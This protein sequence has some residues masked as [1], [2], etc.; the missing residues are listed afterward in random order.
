MQSAMRPCAYSTILPEMCGEG[1]EQACSQKPPPAKVMRARRW[2]DDADSDQ[3]RAEWEANWFSSAFL[4]PEAE[5]VDAARTLSDA[6]LAR[7]FGVSLTCVQ[8]RRKI[9]GMTV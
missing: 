9:L 6:G 4:M 1:W 8:T 3:K 7:K 2:V 5:F